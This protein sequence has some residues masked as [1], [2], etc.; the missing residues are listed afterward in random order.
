LNQFLS[1][2]RVLSI[3]KHWVEAGT[4]SFW[5]VSIDYL[6]GNAAVPKS[7]PSNHQGR[8]DY[9]EILSPEDFVI[10]SQLR[11]MRKAAAQTEGGAG[12]PD[13]LERTPRKNGA[14][15]PDHSESTPGDRWSGERKSGEVRGTHSGRPDTLRSFTARQGD[16][17]SEPRRG[18]I[19]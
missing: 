18:G 2:H 5:S 4:N 6:T 16:V 19:T 7:I 1:S 11:E 9:R 3:K 14:V 10:F 17:G 13:F 8:I 12:V 15:S